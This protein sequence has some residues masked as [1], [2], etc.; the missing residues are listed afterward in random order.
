MPL[1]CQRLQIYRFF[2]W[3]VI[4]M[5]VTSHG[6]AEERRSLLNHL[7]RHLEWLKNHDPTLVSSY[8]SSEFSYERHD[9]D[10]D[11]YKI[12]NTLRWCY[13]ISKELDLGLQMMIPIKWQ[14]TTTSNDFG[15]G[16]IELRPAII[17]RISHTVLYALG[18][19]TVIDSAT[20]SS[21]GQCLDPTPYCRTPL[22]YEH[23]H[24]YG[25]EC[26]IQRHPDG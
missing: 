23:T 19:N 2:I 1:C 16:D 6:M 25:I 20:E 18:I 14:E 9:G 8:I 11:F 24:Q 22:G 15:L 10:A 12:N 17:G 7:H 26:G 13:P 5:L 3:V 21:L 4:I